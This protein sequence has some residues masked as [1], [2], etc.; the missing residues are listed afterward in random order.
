MIYIYKSLFFNFKLFEKYLLWKD[1]FCHT[2]YKDIVCHTLYK[3][4]VYHTLYYDI[5]CHTL[6]NDI[7]CHTLY[8]SYT[9]F[10]FLFIH[11]FPFY[12]S[13]VAVQ[14]NKN[15][16]LDQCFNSIISITRSY[17]HLL[18]VSLVHY[19]RT[20]QIVLIIIP[21]RCTNMDWESTSFRQFLCPSS[22]V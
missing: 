13:I 6:H 19:Q 14:D 10:Y 22:G 17:M 15:T 21:S 16:Q 4:I 7:V 9:T 2:F 18:Q 11:S 8:N 20:L 3:D 5:M 12:S 1:I